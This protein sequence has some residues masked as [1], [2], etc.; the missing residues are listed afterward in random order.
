M[1]MEEHEAES[2]LNWRTMFEDD[3]NSA[4]ENPGHGHTRT[5]LSTSDGSGKSRMQ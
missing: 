1:L 3:L 5:V 2:Y 4:E